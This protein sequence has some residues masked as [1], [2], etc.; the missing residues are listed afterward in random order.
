[1]EPRCNNILK[2]LTECLKDNRVYDVNSCKYYLLAIQL[3]QL[4]K[5]RVNMGT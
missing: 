1:M 2:K 3:C 5:N 4:Y